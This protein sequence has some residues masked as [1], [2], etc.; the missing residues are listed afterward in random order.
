METFQR[1]SFNYLRTFCGAAALD[2]LQTAYVVS[3]GMVVQLNLCIYHD[4]E[5][6]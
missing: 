1:T 4:T 5:I 2:V 3:R 6:S